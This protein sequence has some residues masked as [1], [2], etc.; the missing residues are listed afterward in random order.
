MSPT[1]GITPGG[2]GFGRRRIKEDDNKL[3]MTNAEFEH[4]CYNAAK[5]VD[6]NKEKEQELTKE[7]FSKIS[8]R[9]MIKNPVNLNK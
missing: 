3:E 7:L 4:M 5:R 8:P 9:N 6:E 1:G 2:F